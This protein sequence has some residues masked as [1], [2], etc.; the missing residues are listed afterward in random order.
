MVTSGF[1]QAA[2]EGSPDI[3][4]PGGGNRVYV[5]DPALHPVPAGVPGELCVGGAQVARGYLGRPALTAERFVADP[6]AAVPGARMYR[7]GDRVRWRADGTLDFMGRRGR[8]GEDPR[9]SHRAGGGRGRAAAPARRGRLRRR[10]PGPTW[11]ATRAWWRTW[12]AAVDA[13]ALRAALRRDL[14][15]YLVPSAFVVLDRLPVTPNGK[16][17]REALPAPRLRIRAEAA[18]PRRER[19]LE[20]TLAEVWREVLGVERVGRDD[21]FFELGGH[22]LRM[23]RLQARLRD[24]L[25]R[26]VSIVD[27]FR[28]PTVASLAEHLGADAAEPPGRRG[29]RPGREAPGIGRRARGR[30]RALHRRGS[31][32]MSEAF[33]PGGEPVQAIAVIGMAGRF[34][35]A[36]D[37]ERFWSNLREGVHS[38][39]FLHG[40]GAAGG[41][42]FPGRAC[43]TR[44]TSGPAACWRAPTSSTPPSSASTRAR[45]R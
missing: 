25:G 14:P 31:R 6:F 21:G 15:D 2:G 26:D 35:G 7:T 29:E 20:E 36:A 43:A 17:D 3:G 12:P 41:R 27:L 28:F 39:R 13:D 38:I 37:V 30:V 5:L 8:A 34:P 22:S 9:L 18:T 10:P 44:R 4:R 32:A 11:P 33:Q 42:R 19:P 16:V 23:P 40:R 1:V 24:A 45:R